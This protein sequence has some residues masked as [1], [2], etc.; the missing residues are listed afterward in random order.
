MPRT[1]PNAGPSKPVT[2]T[3]RLMNPWIAFFITIAVRLVLAMSY[4]V[5][6]RGVTEPWVFHPPRG[7]PLGSNSTLAYHTADGERV[8]AQPL[9]RFSLIPAPLDAG[10]WREV[11]FLRAHFSEHGIPDY[12]L[13]ISPWYVRFLPPFLACRPWPAAWLGLCDGLTAFFLA[14][15]PSCTPTLLYAGFVFNPFMVLPA[16]Y[17]SIM[18]LEWFLLAIV[19]EG[20][21]QRR[22]RPW[23]FLLALIASIAL[24]SSFLAVPVM[25]LYPMGVRCRGVAI[26]SAAA[27]S[28]VVGAYALLYRVYTEDVFQRTAAYIPIDHG[29]LWYVKM[30]IF[31]AFERCLEIA[32]V[33]IP[34]VITLPTAV[35]IPPFAVTEVSSSRHTPLVADVKV[36]MV[37]FAIA[38]SVMFRSF[39]TIPFWCLVVLFMYA[40]RTPAAA[41][42]PDISESDSEKRPVGDFQSVKLD[43]F[44]PIFTFL[45]TVPAVWGF[46]LAYGFW[47]VS[48]MNWIFFFNMSFLFS[49]VGYLIIWMNAVIVDITN[50]ESRAELEGI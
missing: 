31:P 29:T 42:L 5:L 43:M 49:C 15:W 24:G 45:I 13:S 19:V 2:P 7:F 32:L 33:I 44:F 41:A 18:P 9:L 28:L 11:G 17:E 4:D 14:G 40:N 3:S 48:N 6:E 22:Q 46:Y 34:A 20:C 35:A 37:C 25:L 16:L 1:H 47:E 50:R 39:L 26:G 36:F 38:I 10:V 21:R 23:V 30:S 8:V 27:L 12:L